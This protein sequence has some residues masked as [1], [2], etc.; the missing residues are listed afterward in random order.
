[1]NEHFV[2]Y[3]LANKKHGTLYTGVT[4]DLVRRVYQHKGK[5]VRG[6]SAK[7]K[8]NKLVYFEIFEDPLTAI[9]GE[10]QLKKWLREWKL[11]LIE[12]KNPEWVDLWETLIWNFCDYGFRLSFA[13][14]T[15]PE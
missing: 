7:Y 14:L 5:F 6:F 3:I 8:I 12:T 2:V 9:A 4:N 1:M 15:R 13:A 10:K 11:Q